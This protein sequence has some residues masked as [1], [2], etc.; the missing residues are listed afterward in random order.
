MFCRRNC[1]VYSNIPVFSKS[2]LW[3]RVSHRQR[4]VF[5]IAAF[6]LDYYTKRLPYYILVYSLWWPGKEEESFPDLVFLSE[7]LERSQ[8]SEKYRKLACILAGS[9]TMSLFAGCI[10]NGDV[11]PEEKNESTDT[12]EQAATKRHRR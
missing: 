5:L 10:G 7:K 11:V 4:S 9:M 3:F 12:E 6:R 1:A 2:I 8:N